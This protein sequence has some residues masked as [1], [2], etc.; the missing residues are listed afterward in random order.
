MEAVS[1]DETLV[2]IS[3]YKTIQ[4]DTPDKCVVVMIYLGSVRFCNLSIFPYSVKYSSNLV[5]PSVVHH[6]QNP[7]EPS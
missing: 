6:R 5:I 4:S 1:S 3:A 2:R 7:L